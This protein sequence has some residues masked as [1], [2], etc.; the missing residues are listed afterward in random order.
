MFPCILTRFV[1]L[2]AAA[3]FFKNHPPPPTHPPLCSHC[4]PPVRL[5]T[6]ASGPCR[7]GG[8]C[9]EEAGSYR[10]VCPYRFTGK[11]CEVGESCCSVSTVKAEAAVGQEREFRR[12]LWSNLLHLKLFSLILLS[13]C[14]KANFKELQ[15]K[16]R[17]F[18]L[19]RTAGVM[20]C[21]AP[22]RPLCVCV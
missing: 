3:F 11:H 22:Q 9:K 7:N 5:N 13:P 15:G 17:Y 8:S 20:T 1:D 6:C 16:K 2:R 10:C 14:C 19:N 21:R 4:L 18:A 12:I